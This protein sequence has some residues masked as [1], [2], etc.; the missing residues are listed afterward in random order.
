MNNKIKS[1]INHAGAILFDLD[2]T[3]I[4]SM[5]IHYNAWLEVLHEV[6]ATIAKQDFYLLE[7]TNIYEL[8][9]RL[10][11]ISDKN[12][13]HQ[14]IDR[15]DQIFTKSYKFSL[16]DGVSE[17]IEKMSEK[18]VPMGIVTTS[19]MR[20]IEQTIPER[21]REQFS[22]IVTSDEGV[23][24]K[25]HPR[26]Y[27]AAAEKLAVS[28]EEIVVFENAPLGIQSAKS[29][30]MRCIAVESTLDKSQLVGADYYIKNFRFFSDIWQGKDAEKSANH[31]GKIRTRS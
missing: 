18:K 5:G 29:A 23:P 8:M 31:Y 7:G 12:A 30:G 28:P 14:L 11:N 19:S 25:P 10:A 22:V 13:I 16:I 6:P 4:D 21:F 1:A 15:K 17:F 2:G 9:G 26:P 27:L 3:L 24:G 20:R